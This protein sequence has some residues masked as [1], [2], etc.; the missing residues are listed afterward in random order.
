MPGD[1]IAAWRHEVAQHQPAEADLG[2]AASRG[3]GRRQDSACVPAAKAT[4]M[5][6]LQTGARP[7]SATTGGPA[8]RRSMI[9]PRRATSGRHPNDSKIRIPRAAWNHLLADGLSRVGALTKWG[10]RPR[11]K[12][13]VATARAESP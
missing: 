10:A 8:R 13:R 9:L 5:V 1:S 6:K 2:G 12:G 3:G 7:Q 4:E 11:A